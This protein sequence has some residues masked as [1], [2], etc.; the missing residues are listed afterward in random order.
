[1]STGKCSGLSFIDKSSVTPEPVLVTVTTFTTE[2]DVDVVTNTVTV[3]E[4]S[5]QSTR[6][7]LIR[8]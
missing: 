2:I 5:L 4:V 6:I 3:T 1:M 7:L 8:G